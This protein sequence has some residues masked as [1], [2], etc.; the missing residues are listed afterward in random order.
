MF[1]VLAEESS[2]S[3]TL[4]RKQRVHEGIDMCSSRLSRGGEGGGREPG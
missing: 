2:V 4:E 1:H 3:R